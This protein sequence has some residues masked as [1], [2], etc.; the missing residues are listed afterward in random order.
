MVDIGARFWKTDMA[1]LWWMGAPYPDMAVPYVG[2]YV[3]FL[4]LCYGPP[5]TI[6]N[7]VLDFPQ[8]SIDN[9]VYKASVGTII[10]AGID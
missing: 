8:S 1:I 3:G 6:N 5:S 10:W 2:W 7:I 9:T 4:A